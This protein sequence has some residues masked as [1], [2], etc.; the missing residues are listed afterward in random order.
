MKKIHDRILKKKEDSAIITE[1]IE[2]TEKGLRTYQKE[3]I[4]K[5]IENNYR[6][7]FA[8]ATGTGKTWN[9]C[10]CINRLQQKEKRTVTIIAAPY[11][12]LVEQWKSAVEDYNNEFPEEDR[13]KI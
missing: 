1:P 2:S 12:H 11:T 9:A 6:G 13:I 8:M 5:W 7:I 10:G 3:A 4:E